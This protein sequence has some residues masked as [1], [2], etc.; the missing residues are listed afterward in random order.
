MPHDD[1]ASSEGSRSAPTPGGTAGRLPS[2]ALVSEQTQAVRAKFDM[3][4]APPSELADLDAGLPELPDAYGDNRIALLPRDPRWLYAY[5]D[6]TNQ[7]KD[8][9]RRRGGRNLML[10]LYDVTD[11]EFDGSNAHG[12]WEH[13]VHELARNRYLEVPVAGRQYCLELGYLGERGEWLVLGRSN[14]VATPPDRPSAR[15]HDV[16][17]TIPFDQPLRGRPLPAESPPAARPGLRDALSGPPSFLG[18]SMGAS[19]GWLRAE[20]P[21]PG[22]SGLVGSLAAIPSSPQPGAGPDRSFWLRA[23]AELIVY[24]ATEPGAQL[25]IGGQKVP[26][27]PDGTFYLRIHFPDGTQD[28]PIEAV[29]ADGSEERSIRLTFD[30]RTE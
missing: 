27:N 14:S 24:G 8:E 21:G 26:L 12:T 17:V 7:H 19:G 28:F 6:M 20:A 13:E 2:G 9:A 30:R 10:R 4:T 15:V 23:D 25:T 18:A 1:S 22:W 5:W 29:A 16:F 11:I 3:G